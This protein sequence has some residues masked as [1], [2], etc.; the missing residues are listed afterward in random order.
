MPTTGRRLQ[1]R[2][3]LSP[4][5]MDT[6]GFEGLYGGQENHDDVDLFDEAVQARDDGSP[7]P[8]LGHAG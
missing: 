3:G 2:R 7:T 6:P 4:R 1:R 8:S 5:G